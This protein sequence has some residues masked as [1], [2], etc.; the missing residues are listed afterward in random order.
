MGP[1]D[2][3][4][5][6]REGAAAALARPLDGLLHRLE[7]GA[8]VLARLAGGLVLATALVVGVEVALRGLAGYSLGVMHEMSGYVLAIVSAWSFTFAL[9]CKQHIRI[10]IAYLYMPAGVQRLMDV[11][12][13]GFLAVFAVLLAS[14]AWEVLSRAWL[15]GSTATTG[16]ATPL[17][18]PQS[19]WFFGLFLFALAV[20]LVLA[21]LVLALLSGEQAR[22]AALAGGGH[23]EDP[24]AAPA[25]GRSR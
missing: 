2:R 1:D 24:D 4:A 13:Y 12:A 25:A 14:A 17:W 21:R 20:T 6:R 9:F 16:L 7:G 22:A 3:D 8:R 23:A 5:G 11:L 18:I 19:A 10:D 15:R